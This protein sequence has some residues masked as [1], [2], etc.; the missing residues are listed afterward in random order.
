MR[1]VIGFLCLRR[2][3]RRRIGYCTDVLLDDVL[4]ESSQ[5]SAKGPMSKMRTPLL[6]KVLTV[7]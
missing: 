2:S 5:R 4:L 3:L 6:T 1:L 7:R